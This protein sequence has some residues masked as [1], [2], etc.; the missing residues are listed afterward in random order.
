MEFH[1]EQNMH[2]C[3]TRPTQYPSRPYSHVL[4]IFASRASKAW[5]VGWFSRNAYTTKRQACMH[6]SINSYPISAATSKPMKQS[7][8][9]CFTSASYGQC[10]CKSV[11]SIAKCSS[12]LL[13]TWTCCSV[14]SC[15][16]C[17]LR[18]EWWGFRKFGDGM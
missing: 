7:G 9:S 8:I 17:V 18:M 10:S 14:F 16:S 2:F 13:F 15:C 3:R 4:H 5:L 11:A 1:H 12:L 6:A